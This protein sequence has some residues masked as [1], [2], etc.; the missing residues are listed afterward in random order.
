MNGRYQVG[1][2]GHRG[3]SSAISLFIRQVGNELET[4]HSSVQYLVRH[5]GW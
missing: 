1:A 5:S 4:G 2:T 3:R